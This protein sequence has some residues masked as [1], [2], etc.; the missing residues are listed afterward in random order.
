MRQLLHTGRLCL[1]K[2]FASKDRN[3]TV[4]RLIDENTALL[5]HFFQVATA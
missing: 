5:H 1:R 3:R 4:Q 2:I